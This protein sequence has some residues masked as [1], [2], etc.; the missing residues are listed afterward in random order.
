[1]Q[2]RPGATTGGLTDAG[3]TWY[4]N[5]SNIPSNTPG[6]ATLS[7][8]GVNNLPHAWPLPISLKPLGS[9]TCDWRVGLEF[10]V[11]FPLNSGSGT[12]ALHDVT[13]RPASAQ[14][15]LRPRD[16]RRQADEHQPSGL[17]TTWSSEVADRPELRAERR[18]S[19]QDQGHDPARHGRDHP[20]E[21]GRDRR[22]RLLIR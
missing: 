21:P 16:L 3:G 12:S 1:M 6:L 19:L 8:F 13:I 22:D 7:G 17:V 15:V 18:H 2:Q 11:W 14:L 20:A 5:Y 9:P 10:G 4:V